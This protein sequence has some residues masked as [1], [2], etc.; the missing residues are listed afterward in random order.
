MAM[1]KAE[2]CV[3]LIPSMIITV[4]GAFGPKQCQGYDQKT[5]DH[6]ASLCGWAMTLFITYEGH[7]LNSGNN[8]VSLKRI[9]LY[10][11]CIHIWK[12][13]FVPDIYYRTFVLNGLVLRIQCHYKDNTVKT[14]SFAGKSRFVAY[15][16]REINICRKFILYIRNLIF[17]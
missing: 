11:L 8:V 1:L 17:Q 13:Q 12:E 4:V 10:I 9:G 6:N 2:V 3:Y 15:A 7:F 16:P 5:Y 14:L